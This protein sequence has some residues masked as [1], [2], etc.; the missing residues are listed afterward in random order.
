MAVKQLENCI[1]C[2]TRL[3]ANYAEERDCAETK[4]W[5]LKNTK[6][7]EMSKIFWWKISLAVQDSSMIAICRFDK[8][9]MKYIFEW[10]ILILVPNN[11]KLSMQFDREFWWC[12]HFLDR[13]TFLKLDVQ[14]IRQGC[15]RFL[16]ISDPRWD[17]P[18]SDI[19]I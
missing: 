3:P 9:H 7:H 15:R 19:F 6:A 2:Q 17:Q 13:Q 8:I 16:T 11:Q 18:I 12:H 5:K 10:K 4:L 1:S 14:K